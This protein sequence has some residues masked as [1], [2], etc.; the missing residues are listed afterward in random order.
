V[1]PLLLPKALF[2]V[3]SPHMRKV[4]GMEVIQTI[5]KRTLKEFTRS[6]NYLLCYFQKYNADSYQGE[7]NIGASLNVS[8][9]SFRDQTFKADGTQSEPTDKVAPAREHDSGPEAFH[10]NWAHGATNANTGLPMGAV[11]DIGKRMPHSR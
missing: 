8:H 4:G 10:F 9:S 11:Q 3:V 2:L 6:A 7:D 1:A 5:S